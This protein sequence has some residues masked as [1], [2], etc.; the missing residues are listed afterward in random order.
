MWDSCKSCFEFTIAKVVSMFTEVGVL[1]F[2]AALMLMWCGSVE[3]I[4]QHLPL[5]LP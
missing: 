4:F 5:R 3:A 2:E 1:I